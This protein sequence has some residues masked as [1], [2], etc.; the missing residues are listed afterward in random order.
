MKKRYRIKK[1][2]EMDDVFAERKSFGDSHFVI[3]RKANEQKHFRFAISIGRKYGSSVER[4][5]CKRRLRAIIHSHKEQI[6][7]SF[8]FVIVVK[9]KARELDFNQMQNKVLLL[10]QKSKI[11]ESI[12]VKHA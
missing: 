2:T 11:I 5:L 6:S 1:I 8:M 10:L 12:E 9:P 3:Y 4:N 7:S